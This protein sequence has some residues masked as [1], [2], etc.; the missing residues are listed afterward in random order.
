MSQ[1]GDE[2]I[3]RL[4][5]DGSALSGGLADAQAQVEAASAKMQEAAQAASESMSGASAETAGAWDAMAANIGASVDAVKAEIADMAAS[6]RA[7][8]ALLNEIAAGTAT[9]FDALVTQE[10]ELSAA[11]DA[12]TISAQAYADAMDALDAQTVTLT[13]ASEA[14]AAAQAELLAAQDAQTARWA[15]QDAAIAANTGELEA[16]TVAKEENATAGGGNVRFHGIYGS[17]G[18]VLTAFT[19]PAIGGL[20]ALAAALGV[21]SAAGGHAADEIG[22]LDEALL[23]SG[24]DANLTSGQLQQ[25][26]DQIGAS[27]ATIGDASAVLAQLAASGQFTGDQIEAVGKAAVVMAQLTGTSTKQAADDL[28]RMAEDPQSAIDKLDQQFHFLTST[29][30]EQIN[31]MLQDGNASGAVAT[32]FGAL[33]A[34]TKDLAHAAQDAIPIYDRLGDAIANVWNKAGEAVRAST[35]HGTLQEELKYYQGLLVGYPAGSGKNNPEITQAREKI[36]EIEAALASQS[37]ATREATMLHAD[38]QRHMVQSGKSGLSADEARLRYA[39]SAGNMT[40]AQRAAYEREYWQGIRAS[41][42]AG[43]AVGEAAYEHLQSLGAHAHAAAMHFHM[44]A[45]ANA[46]WDVGRMGHY[47]TAMMGAEA[48]KIAAQKH[49]AEI[50]SAV[51]STDLQAQA[52]HQVALQEMKRQHIEAMASM[53]T[54]GGGAAIEQERQVADAIYKIKLAELEKE[55]ALEATKPV[56]VA[57]I[58]SEIVRLGDAHAATMQSLSDKAAAQQI[59]DAQGVVSPVLSTFSQVTAG[60]VEG[61]LTRQQAELRM[62]DALVAHEINWGIQKLVNFI[63]IDNAKTIAHAEGEAKRLALTVA[64]EAESAAIHVAHAVEYIAT[65]AAKAAAAAFTALAGIPVIGPALAVAASVAAGAEVL[66]LVGKVAS[67]EGGWDRVPFDNAPALLHK[68][69]MVLPADL[70]E[71]VRNMSGGGGNTYHYHIHAND[72]QG[73]ENM[74]K[75]NPGA[76]VRALGH[77]HRIGATA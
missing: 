6:A 9:S 5:A 43:S 51:Q 73:F 7:P 32:A 12:G 68:D 37:A 75:R 62:G 13:A 61:T 47:D 71:G 34:R 26:A 25:M 4:I 35:G 67:A 44:P 17:I 27:N 3:V 48:H 24:N 33:E 29:Q 10:T 30:R 1:S 20:A 2:I 54:I 16:N 11:F 66:S 41:V 38:Q 57:R 19:N 15:A 23:V 40:P 55:K 21:V 60:F 53:G 36:K 58:N 70:A 74:L 49:A 31:T 64:S 42:P 52:G 28:I 8:L 45:G 65:E 77:A 63:T 50:Q 46:G 39:E 18:Q 72:A 14:A 56:E 76:L 22:A 59:K 69:E